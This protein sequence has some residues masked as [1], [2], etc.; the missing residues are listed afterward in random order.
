MTTNLYKPG[1]FLICLLLAA[2]S[3]PQADPTSPDISTPA[4]SDALDVMVTDDAPVVAPI[5]LDSAIVTGTLENGMRY[6]IRHNEKPEDRVELRLAVNA[7]SILEE[8]D[9]RGL[10]HF[11]EHMAFNGT[12]QFEKQELVDYLELIGTRFGPDLNAYTSFDET[13]YML[14]VRSDSAEILQTG[15]EILKEWAFNISLDPDEVEKERGV[16]IEEW[17]LGRGAS[18]RISDKQLPILLA[19]SEYV[20][21]L[22]I[23]LPE[24][25]EN[26]DPVRLH[27]FYDKWYRP[28]LMAIV[29]VGDIDVDSIEAHIQHLFDVAPE[30]ESVD[31]TTFSVPDHDETLF[32]ATT[33]PEAPYSSA[34]IVYKHP[35]KPFLTEQ[36]FR[37]QVVEQ[38]FS[39]ILNSRLDELRQLAQPPYIVAGAGRGSYVRTKDFYNVNAIVQEA[40]FEIAISTMLTEV[41]RIRRFGFT[42]SEFDR[43]VSSYLRWYESAYNERDKTES[44]V[45]ASE[46]VRHFLENEA[47]PGIA[48]E[49]ELVQSLLPTVTLTE[50][51]READHW[52]TEKNRVV[53]L[54]GPDG[55]TMP[56]SMQ[57]MQLIQDVSTLDLEP[58]EDKQSDLPIL[59]AT[60]TAGTIEEESRDDELGV[61]R[62]TLSNGARVVLKPT[63]FKNDE[64]IFAAFS[65]GGTSLYPDEL[66]TPADFASTLV[67]QSGVGQHD[68]VTLDKLLSDKLVSIGPSIG[69]MSESLSGGAAPRDLETLMQLIHGYFVYPRAD[70]TAYESF[71]NRIGSLVESF[72]ADPNRAFLDTLSVTLSQYHPRRRVITADVLEEMDLQ[73]SYDIYKDRFAD[74]SDFAF[75]LV[76]SFSIDEMRPFIETYLASIPGSGRTESWKDLGVQPPEGVVSKTVKRGLEQQARAQLV[77]S[78]DVEWNLHNRRM[79]SALT[80]VLDIRLRETLREDLG[81][82]YGVQVGGSVSRYPRNAYS[83]S[84]G[85]GCDPDRVQELL[86]SVFDQIE[87]LKQEPPDQEYV[88]KTREIM[89]N[90]YQQG[91]KQNGNWLQWLQFYDRNELD[92][93]MIFTGIPEFTS[94]LTPE[95]IQEAATRYLDRSN[96]VQVILLPEDSDGS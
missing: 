6:L 73:K 62:M 61:T 48:F 56:D 19:G 58:F 53:M 60:P 51:N 72:R 17:R 45:F 85:F 79:M 86:V 22:P 71:K 64:I 65:S 90:G 41:E 69:E 96:Y 82:T 93:K 16:V 54:S 43:A 83:L 28:D 12:E 44:E 63:D 35:L 15:L 10:A 11:L 21:R 5:P 78:G 80:N 37:G 40:N 47:V 68:P 24:V 66:D 14:Q 88:D 25:L 20:N 92:P 84:I 39:D 95:M 55:V 52:L 36:D 67:A 7:G 23:G 42:R 87:L 13:V 59:P 3:G 30:S 75:Y 49:Y 34:S 81:G 1:I 31:R 76:G 9:Q 33:D 38:L 50:V 27:D 77:F 4:V 46:Y 74:A 57:V 94:N 91:L 8:E 29:V 32:V 18:A 26:F 2:C 89:M 70:S